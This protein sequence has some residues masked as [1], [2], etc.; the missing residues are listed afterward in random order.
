[1]PVSS[2]EVRGAY[3]FILGRE[4]ESEEVV[5][6]HQRHHANLSALRADFLSSEEFR[7]LSLMRPSQWLVPLGSRA[8][9]IETVTDMT[10]L[11]AIVAETAA[12]W[13]SVGKTAPHESV[14]AYDEYKP[15]RF[16]ENEAAFFETGKGDLAMLLGILNR[17]GRPVEDFCRCVEFGCGVGRV[18]PQLA[19][20][21]PTIVALD[22]SRPHLELAQAHVKGLGYRNVTFLQ[23]TPE[24]LHP[25]SGYDLWFSKLVLQHNPPPVTLHILDKMFTGLAP[26]GV[27]VVHLRTYWIG[28]S[29]DV[30]DY[31]ANNAGQ[32]MEMHVTPQ[33]PIL[34]LAW[35]HGC[36]LLDVREEGATPEWLTNIFVFQKVDALH[37]VP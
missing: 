14:L 5:R 25:I 12:C 15:D 8:Q 19:A 4:P 26:A 33:K 23:V 20:T 31:L 34:E 1:M 37:V 35:R 22:I 6:F 24:D 16:P 29:F 27:A 3:R 9:A 21:F 28:Y 2:D 32:E 7:S 17:I 36:C 18:T 11:R 13:D 10:T 30:A